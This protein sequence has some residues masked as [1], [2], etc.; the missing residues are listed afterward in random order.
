MFKCFK[1]TFVATGA[2]PTVRLR[3]QAKKGRLR[4]PHRVQ[5]SVYLCIVLYTTQYSRVA[6]DCT[7][8][9]VWLVSS[10]VYLI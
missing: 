7:P 2:D 3:L 6:L 10:T 1:F 5:Y 9:P 4:T 8:P